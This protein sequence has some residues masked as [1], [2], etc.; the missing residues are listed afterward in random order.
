[1]A[2]RHLTHVVQ[3][4]RRATLPGEDAG[5]TDGQLLERYVRGREEAAF[6]ALVRRH[7]PM[8]WGV[9]RRMLR[10]EQDAEDAFQATFLVLVRKAASVTPR[11]MVANWLYGVARHVAL[12]AR[13]AATRRRGREKQVTAMPEPARD[14]TELWDGLQPLLD[15]ELGRLP[16]KYRAVIVL[17]DLEGKT[18]K[19]AARH[20]NL[21]EGTVASR[22]AAAR[23]LLAK[24]LARHGLAVSGGVLAAVLSE[25]AASARV[26]ASVA[27]STI[28]AASHFA[29]GQAAAPGAA[30]VKAV[31]LA[32]G[33]LKT[34]LLTRLKN[35]T[36]VLVA[37]ATALGTG[38]AALTQQVGAGKTAD[39]AAQQHSANQPATE[40]K[41]SETGTTVVSGVLRAV[42]AEKNTLTVSHRDGDRTFTVASDA[43]VVNNG[44][45]G[46]LAEL[47]T[48][49]F[50]TLSLLADQKTVRNIEAVGPNAGGALKAVDV[51]K[52]TL[53]FDEKDSVG[54]LHERT[55]VVTKNATILIDGRPGKL[56]GLPLGAMVSVSW[57]MDPKTVRN[58]QAS[59]R[60]YYAVPVEAID[61]AKGAI[62]FGEERA[63]AELAG[64]TFPVARDAT[65]RIDDKNGKL[66]EI[67]KGAF[68]HPIFSADHKTVHWLTAEGRGFPVALVKAVDAAKNTIT[69]DDDKAPEELAGKT[70]P[71]ARDA[72]IQIDGKPGK[73]TGVPP[74]A[75]VTLRLSLDQKTARTIQAEGR[76]FPAALVKAVD[77][78]KGTITFDD[79]K[80]PEELAGRTF[81]VARDAAIQIDGKPGKLAS[82]PPGANVNLSLS[83]DQK[84][85]RA[86][87]AEGRSFPGA[88]V[89]AV[90]AAKGTITFDDDRA[91][92]EL[93]GKTLSVA[94]DAAIRIDGKP[95]NLTALPPGVNISLTLSVHQKTVRNLSAEGPQV[96]APGDAVVESVDP[97]KNTITVEINGEGQ[98]TF[99][100]ARDASIAIDG[101]PGKLAGVHKEASVTLTLRVDQKT[102]GRIEAKSP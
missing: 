92:E 29:A 2:A 96:G 84:T 22:L 90:D 5:R 56:T 17:C 74:G 85:A 60:S 67:P 63:P 39:Q 45:P 11:E 99:P 8:V 80:A 41:R 73:L 52:R 21:P 50:V 6:A 64:K 16:D 69:F 65:I 3:T 100:V 97:E 66:A 101:K 1:M 58:V 46:N 54:E 79:D 37:V 81:P 28:R 55:F 4:L 87:A 32:E 26:P 62:T 98:K 19:E 30:S 61:A 18:R 42:D 95:G 12:K 75:I 9:C 89:K 72:N 36:A 48:R 70:F 78:A 53:T 83:A 91:P 15:Q 94:K 93:A 24:R 82:V 13:A 86:L 35:A 77:A 102:V 88:L 20:F 14:Q 31:A 47:P 23:G 34:M 40:K 7:G 43:A 49:A 38:A 76:Q 51:A 10:H 33:V 71:V 59:G 57:F 68:V 27:S 44:R 25:R